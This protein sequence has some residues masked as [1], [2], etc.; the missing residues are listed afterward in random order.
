M[1]NCVNN[2]KR[3]LK[4]KWWNDDLTVKWNHVC[5][6]ENQYLH[7]TTVN[8][9]T[10][11]RQFYAK[12]RKEIDELVQKSRRQYWHSCQEEL[13]NLNKNYPRQFWRKI[14]KFGFGNERQSI[15][16]NEML[17]ND[18]SVTNNMDDVLQK[19]KNSF[20]E[21]TLLDAK[22]IG[23]DSVADL[24]K[25]EDN[26]HIGQRLVYDKMKGNEPFGMCQA[27]MSQTA[28]ANQ[29]YSTRMTIY[30]LVVRLRN[31]GTPSDR[32]CFGRHRVRR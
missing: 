6:A 32:Q 24:D 7:C 16:P 11:L 12:K 18:G 3:R 2:R 22:S 14:G 17:Q 8:N 1:L 10:Y 31:T 15:I 19:W 29:F 27:G 26:P 9:N 23:T 25:S 5:Q 13:V 28:V 4:K 21:N 30:R 20:H